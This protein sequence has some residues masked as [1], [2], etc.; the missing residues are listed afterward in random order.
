MEDRAP[1]PV[2][3]AAAAAAATGRQ[4]RTAGAAHGRLMR[5]A[6][7]ASTGTAVVLIVVKLV[8]WGITGS[9][10][11]LSTLIDSALD[12]AASLLNLFAVHHALQPADREHR[13]GH[14]K[15][16]A[17][18][19]LGQSAFI[20]GSGTLLLVE[21]VNRLVHPAEIARGEWGIAV[22]AFSIAATAALV[23]FQK[24]VLAKTDSVA[25]AA[26]SLHYTGDVMI[27][28]SVAVSLALSMATGWSFTDPLF[29]IAIGGYL[30]YT[31]WRVALKSLDMLMDHELPDADRD[32]I[33]QIVRGH[34]EVR[35]MHDLRT[36]SSGSQGFIQFHLE[37][38]PQLTLIQAH[39]IADEVEKAV[40]AEFPAFEVIIHEDP[41]GLREDHPRFG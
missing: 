30:L 3:K 9:V 36:R 32:R 29:A 21:A 16:E 20:V 34:P 37:L 22:M 19:G 33:R 6:T 25:I 18:A 14:G 7:Y 5:L 15:A 28:G 4:P 35:N 2:S 8:A 1:L 26:D 24:Y 39:G 27:N 13:F 31:A 11:L 38:D 41:A 40:N 23:K 10:A 17:L 12:V